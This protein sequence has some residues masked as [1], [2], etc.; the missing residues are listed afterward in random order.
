MPKI[1]QL[2]II[3]APASSNYLLV[4]DNNLAKRF[5]FDNLATALANKLSVPVP[6]SST[7]A[8]VAGQIAYDT[9]FIYICVDTNTWRRIPA[10]TF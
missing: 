8:G 3:D 7:D 6:T 9:S 1:T 10:S 5:S 4:I 2:P